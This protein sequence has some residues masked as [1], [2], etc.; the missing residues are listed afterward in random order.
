VW[1]ELELREEWDVVEGR[2][3]VFL[4]FLFFIAGHY[5]GVLLVF[6]GG[7]ACFNDPWLALWGIDMDIPPRSS[8][9]LPPSQGP[10]RGLFLFLPASSITRRLLPCS[11]HHHQRTE[12]PAKLFSTDPPASA[13]SQSHS[14]GY[15]PTDSFF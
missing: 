10:A 15:L 4:F 12:E 9:F 1:W 14:P 5:L 2:V 7:T 11:R 13:K 3:F 8:F 6:N